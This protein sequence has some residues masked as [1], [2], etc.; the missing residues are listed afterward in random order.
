MSDD[1]QEVN[2]HVETPDE[3]NVADSQ[4]ETS[5]CQSESERDTGRVPQDDAG[6]GD[7]QQADPEAEKRECPR[8][9][10]N[11]IAELVRALVSGNIFTAAQCPPEMIGS[12]FMVLALGGLASSE[13]DPESIGMIYEH[14]DRANEMA[15][16]GYPT[17]FSCKFMHKADWAIVV[18][19]AIAAQE[20]LN[21]AAAGES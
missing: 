8:L 12:I 14:M 19:R 4:R 5:T 17:F 20:A 16:N 15:V 13:I 3:H 21:R 9:T 10:G 6:E 11:E 18:E 2:T 7:P 1:V